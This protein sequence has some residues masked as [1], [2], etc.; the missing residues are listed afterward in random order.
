MKSTLILLLSARL[1]EEEGESGVSPQ[2]I[3]SEAINLSEFQEKGPLV[4]QARMKGKIKHALDDDK[5][6]SLKEVSFYPQY[7]E[8]CIIGSDIEQLE[9]MSQLSV[10]S[11]EKS[12]EAAKVR[13]GAYPTMASEAK[14]KEAT[15]AAARE[16]E[17]VRENERRIAESA[18]RRRARDAAAAAAAA[19]V[20]S[21]KSKQAAVTSQSSSD[22]SKQ[23][24]SSPDAR[25]QKSIQRVPTVDKTQLSQK[26]VSRRA[27]SRHDSVQKPPPSYQHPPVEDHRKAPAVVARKRPSNDGRKPDALGATSTKS[28]RSVSSPSPSTSSGRASDDSKS[29]KSEVKSASKP[30]RTAR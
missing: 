11:G 19:Q 8:I 24:I 16:A 28:K 2:K 14:R 22:K 13:K 1:A 20:A 26:S 5:S 15:E 3:D 25:S 6:F 9:G 30:P 27:R 18:I 10:L 23:D 4:M 12:A 29:Q 7:N 17:R 21:D